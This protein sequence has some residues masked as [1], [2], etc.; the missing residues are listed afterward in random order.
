LVQLDKS[1]GDIEQQGTPQSASNFNNMDYGI[2]DNQIAK[3]IMLQYQL[4]R[5]RQIDEHFDAVEDTADLIAEEIAPEV[6]VVTLTNTSKQPF[7]NSKK[8]VAFT[9]TRNNLNYIVEYVIQSFTGGCVG[10][11][12]ISDKALNGF[13]VEFDGGASSVTLK[14]I[15]KG[16]MM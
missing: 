1:P 16:G 12:K 11:V 14:C 10:D 15:A 2:L 3:V 6:S 13:K 7:N 4:N 8:T 9:K 5:D